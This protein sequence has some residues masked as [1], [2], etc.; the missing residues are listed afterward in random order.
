MEISEIYLELR[1]LGLCGSAHEF[2]RKYLGKHQSYYSVL[3]ARKAVPS[4]NILLTLKTALQRTASVLPANKSNVREGAAAKLFVFCAEIENELERRCWE[5][6][7]IA[8]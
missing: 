6:L 4:V 2:S 1:E 3:L 8:I 7:G 5:Q